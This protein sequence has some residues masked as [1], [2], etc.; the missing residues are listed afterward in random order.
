MF[1]PICSRTATE[2][3][4]TFDNDVMDYLKLTYF[5]VKVRLSVHNISGI[6]HDED[7]LFVPVYS[8]IVPV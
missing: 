6:E 7:L 5:Q 3:V 8:R 1:V 2:I 4:E